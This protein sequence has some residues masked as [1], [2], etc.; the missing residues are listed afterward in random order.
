LESLLLQ[1]E[2]AAPTIVEEYLVKSLHIARQ[3]G[4]RLFELR[5]A[6]TFGQ[7]LADRGERRQAVDLLAPVYSWFAEG[8]DTTALKKAKALLEELV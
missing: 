5:T 2:Q 3:Q 6:T 8:I 7:V 4:A 1:S